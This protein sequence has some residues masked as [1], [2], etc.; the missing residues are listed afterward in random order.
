MVSNSK[1]KDRG[2]TSEGESLDDRKRQKINEGERQHSKYSHVLDSLPSEALENVAQKLDR[3]TILNWRRVC[4][5]LDSI[6]AKLFWRHMVV[7]SRREDFHGRSLRQDIDA[8]HN[9]LTAR[10]IRFA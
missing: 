3:R 8:E 2:T 1:E 5:R 10:E 4:R 6:G 7:T 9:T